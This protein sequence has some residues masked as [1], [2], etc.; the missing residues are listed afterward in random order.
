M[1]VLIVVLA[2]LIA[3][4]ANHNR[5]EQ[6]LLETRAQITYQLN[7]AQTDIDFFQSMRFAEEYA[8]IVLRWGRPG[9]TLFTR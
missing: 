5:Q 9:Q 7:Q 2:F 8:M 1:F 6:Q 4:R 3:I